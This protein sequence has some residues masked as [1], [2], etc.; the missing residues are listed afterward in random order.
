MSN[1]EAEQI[2]AGI[3]AY[4]AHDKAFA[5]FQAGERWEAL[6]RMAIVAGEYLCRFKNSDVWEKAGQP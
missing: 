3:I 2:K 4:R 1:F 5:F 6:D